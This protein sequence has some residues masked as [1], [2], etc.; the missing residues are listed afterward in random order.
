[1]LCSP[2]VDY[3][4]VSRFVVHI[5]PHTERLYIPMARPLHEHD[6]SQILPH[7]T[8]ADEDKPFVANIQ[9][10]QMTDWEVEA[11]FSGKYLQSILRCS[12]LTAAA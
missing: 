7:E 10:C 11:Q 12:T 4:L 5:G 9:T 3:G 1:M 2:I 6:F 8:P